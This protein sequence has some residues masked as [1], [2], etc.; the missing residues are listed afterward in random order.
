MKHGHQASTPEGL[1]CNGAE[2]ACAIKHRQQAFTLVELIVTIVISSI[3][4]SFMAMFIAGPIAAFDDQTR[5]AELVDLAESALRRLARDVRRALP[6]SVRVTATGGTVALEMLNSVDGV[7]YREQRRRRSTRTASSISAARTAHFNSVGQFTS[8]T[9][10]V[11][12]DEPL[13]FDLQR[14]CAG[15]GRLRARQRH[16]AGQY[17][18]R[19]R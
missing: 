16:H 11:F 14:R 6:N 17:T 4:V 7:R 3:V 19:H 12:I 5:R 2:I 10:A 18:H 8:I 15:R 13:P 9:R 1:R